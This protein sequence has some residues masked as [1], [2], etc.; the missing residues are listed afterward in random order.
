MNGYGD[1]KIWHR[2][3][4]LK[5]LGE[6]LRDRDF[7]VE[8][9]NT[10]EE[11]TDFILK[12]IPVEASVGIGGSATIRELNIDS[13]LKQRGNKLFDHWESGLSKDEVLNARKK[14]LTSDYFLT[15]ANAITADGQIV[16][17]D[18]VGN[19]V[20]S[21]IFGPKH[22]ISVIGINKI[23]KNL[24]D[25]LWRIKNIATPINA[26]RLGLKTPC[27]L[28]GHCMECKPSASICKITTIIDARPSQTDFTIILT[29]LELGF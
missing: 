6:K 8:I 5:D 21:M 16:N 3:I 24:D 28:K 9:L 18:G 29:P 19:R 4:T 25:A 12:T 17:I 14:Q 27:A 10:K 11:I 20:A 22:V 15:S 26:K 23:A 2:E 13:L 1:V 7:T